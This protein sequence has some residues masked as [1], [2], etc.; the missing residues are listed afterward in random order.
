MHSY[1]VSL[2]IS[3]KALDPSTITS[4][5][6]IE[7]TQVRIEGQTRPGGGSAWVESMWEYEAKASNEEREWLSLEQGL[8][9]LLS[10]FAS[11]QVTLREYQ[12][13][14][15]VS[16]FCGHFT[17]SSNGGPTLSPSLLE[18]LGDFGVELFLDTY[19]SQDSAS[20]A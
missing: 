15:K 14:F 9:S 13:R 19:S 4:E 16:L 17:S 6:G 1:L 11:R 12:Q 7:P 20:G 3:G 10:T 5:L 18:E 2:R 8:Q